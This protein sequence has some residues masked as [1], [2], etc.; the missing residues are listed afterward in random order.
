MI[1]CDSEKASVRVSAAFRTNL[2]QFGLRREEDSPT[3]IRRDI[4][5][6]E[7]EAI[8]AA[9]AWMAAS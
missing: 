7:L 3:E 5:A 9:D 1:S 8:K 4:K 2:I 6:N